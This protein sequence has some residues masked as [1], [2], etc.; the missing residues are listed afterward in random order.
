MNTTLAGTGTLVPGD[1]FVFADHSQRYAVTNT[2]TASGSAHTAVTFTPALVQDVADGVLITFSLND[3]TANLMF[4]R[5]AFA[6]VIAPLPEIGSE[7][8]ARIV[9]V[10]DPVTK[11]SLRSRIYY[12]GNSSEVHVSMDVLYG[13]KTLDPNLAVRGRG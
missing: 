5:N 4:H 1:T 12:V 6:I 8:G 7:L 10:T 9:T 13:V 2:T 3:H 11:M